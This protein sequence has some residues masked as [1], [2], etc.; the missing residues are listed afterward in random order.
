MWNKI[1]SGRI[2]L[3]RNGYCLKHD[4][5]K[6]KTTTAT[7]PISSSR[8]QWKC[9][10]K[11]FG[12]SEKKNGTA[13]FFSANVDISKRDV[14]I[15]WNPMG[16]DRRRPLGPTGAPADGPTAAPDPTRRHQRKHDATLAAGRLSDSGRKSPADEA[17][18]PPGPLPPSTAAVLLVGGMFSSLEGGKWT[19]SIYFIFF[20]NSGEDDRKKR[21]NQEN[22]SFYVLRNR[23]SL[24]LLRK[25][26]YINDQI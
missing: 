20:W 1:E 22:H 18:P 7:S 15:L 23:H 10:W 25:N 3:K 5:F 17:R 26:I 21:K 9:G 11:K 13:I 19:D 6:K 2:D 16:S 8:I 4:F 14:G 12:K 24:W